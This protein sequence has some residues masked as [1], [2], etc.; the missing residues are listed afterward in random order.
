MPFI[1]ERAFEFIIRASREIYP[2]E[3]IALL[4]GDGE[5]I[6][7]VL[8]LPGSSYGESFSSFRRISVPIDHSIVGTVHS[9]PSRNLRP[10]GTDLAN[11][12][13]Y[14]NYHIILRHP[15]SGGEDVACYDCDGERLDLTVI[16]D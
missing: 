3:F 12:C 13:N 4:R 5:T 7:E 8:V 1:T 10:S 15:Y 6:L 9:H 2:N 16:G 14:G 11:F